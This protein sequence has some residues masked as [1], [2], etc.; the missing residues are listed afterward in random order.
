ME[1][2]RLAWDVLTISRSL[3]RFF[4]F[5]FFFK[6]QEWTIGLRRPHNFAAGF[7][8]KFVKHFFFLWKTGVWRET[9]SQFRVLSGVYFSK[10][11]TYTKQ[12]WTIGL[13]RPHNFAAGSGHFLKQLTRNC[14]DFSRTGVWRE[15]SSQFRHLAGVF[16]DKKMSKTDVSPE[17]SSQ[18]C[19]PTRSYYR[20]LHF[21]NGPL[22]WDV[23]TFSRSNL[24]KNDK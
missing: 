9:S 16:R 22:A 6:K 10:K 3:R 4:F 23:L 2:G 5:F 17:T 11:N 19:W 7:A 14:S 18:F 21:K 12:K 15:T 8:L 1:N 13:R 24:W 20:S